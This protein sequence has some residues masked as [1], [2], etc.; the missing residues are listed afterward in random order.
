MTARRALTDTHTPSTVAPRRAA[1]S[2]TDRQLSA[3][4]D[5]IDRLDGQARQYGPT[6]LYGQF[7]GDEARTL[8]RILE[9]DPR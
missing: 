7:C 1:P 2:I 9:G 3:L 8:R 5:H 4:D 6:N